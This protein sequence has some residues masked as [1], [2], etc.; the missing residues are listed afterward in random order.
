MI[1]QHYRVL[2]LFSGAGGAGMGYYRAGFDVYGVD[3]EDH[4]DYP[5][6][7]AIADALDFMAEPGWG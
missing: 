1:E 3:I 4:A 7:S 6:D 5:F 2:D